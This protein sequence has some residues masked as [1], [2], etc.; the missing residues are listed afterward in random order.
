M[1]N[2]M[3]LHIIV[4]FALGMATMVVVSVYSFVFK[5]LDWGRG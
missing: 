4:G 2:I 1:N 3:M 5:I